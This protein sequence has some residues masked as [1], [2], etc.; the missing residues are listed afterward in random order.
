MTRHR[1]GSAEAALAGLSPGAADDARAALD[2]LLP[3]D[4]DLDDLIQLDL[5]SFLWYSLPM[6]WLTDESTHHDVAQALGDAL[7]AAGLDRYAGLCRSPETHELIGRWPADTEGARG[8]FRRLMAASGVGP[9]DTDL[10]RWGSV[11]GIAEHAASRQVSHAL[12]SVIDDGRLVPGARGWKQRA[13]AVVD[14]AMRSRA[15]GELRSLLQSVEAERLSRWLDHHRRNGLQVGAELERELRDPEARGAEH[16]RDDLAFV[17]STLEPLTWFLNEVGDAVTMTQ[18]GYLPRALVLAADDRYDWFDLKP[19][20]SVRSER[21]LL[22]LQQ[23]HELARRERLVTLRRQSLSLSARG[24][25]LVDDPARLAEVVLPALIGKPTW[26]GDTGLAVATFLSQWPVD[27]PLEIDDLQRAAG[28]YLGTHWR[29]G[30]SP[31]D[32]H[33]VNVAVYDV[34]R[35]AGAFGWTTPRPRQMWSQSATLNV[36]GH[37]AVRTA[38]R[39]AAVAPRDRP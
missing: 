6:K 27:E 5:Q 8:Q 35:L 9:S 10:V 38:L 24:R 18:A 3:E 33:S 4:G 31:V 22:Q 37:R 34:L 20:F 17:G 30:A 11:Q 1:R 23:L 25:P 15:P 14:E 36:D 7:A 28:E 16:R 32:S 12:E 19:R 2:W 13:A 26:E 29:V 39:E 21:D